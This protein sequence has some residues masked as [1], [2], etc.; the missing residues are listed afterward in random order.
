MDGYLLAAGDGGRFGREVLR[1]VGIQK[2]PPISVQPIPHNGNLLILLTELT[3]K[4]GLYQ[5]L[6]VV[7]SFIKLT[8]LMFVSRKIIVSLPK[9]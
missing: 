4:A 7:K 8:D 6:I 5:S 3:R 9:Q 2:S 1:Q